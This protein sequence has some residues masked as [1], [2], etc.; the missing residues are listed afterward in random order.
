MKIHLFL[1]L[2]AMVSIVFNKVSAQSP[3]NKSECKHAMKHGGIF[4]GKDSITL[5]EFIKNIE[6]VAGYKLNPNQIKWAQMDF[7]RDDKNGNGLLDMQEMTKVWSRHDTFFRFVYVS[8]QQPSIIKSECKYAMKHG[9]IFNGKDSITL[10][11]FIKNIET[12]A[13]DKLNANQIKGAKMDFERD[14]KNAN[15]LLDVQEMID[16]RLDKPE[17][18]QMFELFDKNQDGFLNISEIRSFTLGLLGNSLDYLKTVIT[19]NFLER[20]LRNKYLGPDNQMDLEEYLRF[21]V[22]SKARCFS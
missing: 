11:E 1:G 9:G 12:V 22:G 18:L 17:H 7:E 8:A 21:K 3:I 5:F 15:G 4:N 13:G 14:D 2:M 16:Q 19:E 20:E 10:F 6:T